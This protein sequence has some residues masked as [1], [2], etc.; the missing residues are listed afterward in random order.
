[1]IFQATEHGAPGNTRRDGVRPFFIRTWVDDV[2][3]EEAGLGIRPWLG[4][5][6]YEENATTLECER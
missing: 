4:I 1:M 3:G 2:V 6:V 5:R